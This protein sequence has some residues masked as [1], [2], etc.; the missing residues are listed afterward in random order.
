MARKTQKPDLVTVDGDLCFWINNGPA[1]RNM[2]DLSDALKNISEES[3]AYHVN[4]EK[5]DFANWALNALQ[6]ET[7]SLKLSKSKNV[8]A[9]IKAVDDRLKKYNV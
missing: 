1:L 8:K 5:N 4:S 2:K 6:D 9:A 3:Y 7:L